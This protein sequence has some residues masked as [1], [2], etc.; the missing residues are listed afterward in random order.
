MLDFIYIVGGLCCCSIILYLCTKGRWLSYLRKK[1][2]L[3][4]LKEIDLL[5]HDVNP[6][7]ISKMARNKE[8]NLIY[9]EIDICS[10]LDLLELVS[11]KPGDILYDLGSGCGKCII[12]A[13][14]AYP[15]I[16]IKGIEL[17]KDL[18]AIAQEKVK[19]HLNKNSLKSKNINIQLIHDNLLNQDFSDANIIFINATAYDAPLWE[20]FM[21]KLILL[22][23]G[24]KIIITSKTLPSPLFAKK[25]AAMEHMSWGWA[26]TYIYQ[27]IV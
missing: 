19:N 12:A 17:I 18:H 10:F 1:R 27:K 6:F 23:C 16:D 21:Q 3:I 7:K 13:H 14:L 26:S 15:Y 4:I 25:Y 11:P 2:Y 22:K 20:K 8:P 9:G 5:F 24:T